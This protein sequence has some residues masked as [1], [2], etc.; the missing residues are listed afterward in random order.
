VRYKLTSATFTHYATV[1]VIH[2]EVVRKRNGARSSVM[3]R[4]GHR[5][6]APTLALGLAPPDPSASSSASSFPPT[7]ALDELE[8][9]VD[10]GSFESMPSLPSIIETMQPLLDD[11]ESVD[12]GELFTRFRAALVKKL[13][14]DQEKSATDKAEN[15]RRKETH[16]VTVI[17]PPPLFM[18]VLMIAYQNLVRAWRD[19]CRQLYAEQV[20]ITN[21]GFCTADR[22]CDSCREDECVFSC[23]DCTGVRFSR[24]CILTEHRYTPLHRIEVRSSLPDPPCSHVFVDVRRWGVSPDV[25]GFSR[26]GHPIEPS[27]RRLSCSHSTF[28]RLHHLQREWRTSSEGRVLRLPPYRPRARTRSSDLSTTLAS[29]DMEAT[30]YSLHVLFHEDVSRYQSS[31]QV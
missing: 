11:D 24:K 23:R 18:L 16:S 14:H 5:Q 3:T 13:G 29:G 22:C 27:P 17:D 19:N 30:S 4:L 6:L 8:S 26:T 9:M 15:K 7:S 28:P 10:M 20:L 25:L 31:E 12:A 2:K 21:T 1:A